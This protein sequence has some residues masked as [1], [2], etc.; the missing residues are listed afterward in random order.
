M[1][2][3]W[4]W[5]S[6]AQGPMHVAPIIPYWVDHSVGLQARKEAEEAERRFSLNSSHLHWTLQHVE[7]DQFVQFFGYASNGKAQLIWVAQQKR[8]FN[9]PSSLVCPRKKQEEEKKKQEEAER[10]AR[11]V[12]KKHTQKKKLHPFGWG[13]GT[14]WDHL[15]PIAFELHALK[16]TQRTNK[17]T[18][19][20]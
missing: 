3:P 14:C 15:K 6:M 2:W 5:K 13:F 8:F 16:L 7:D 9:Q 19:W 12:R 17:Q 4:C 20:K 10:K 18:A 1:L 11:E